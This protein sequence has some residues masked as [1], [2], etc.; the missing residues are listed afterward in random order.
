MRATTGSS[1]SRSA[2]PVDKLDTEFGL[3]GM[4]IHSRLPIISGRRGHESERDPGAVP[5]GS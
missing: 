2:F 3:Y 5:L 4:N 1:A